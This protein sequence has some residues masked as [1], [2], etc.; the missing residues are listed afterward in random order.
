MIKKHCTKFHVFTISRLVGKES[1]MFCDRQIDGKAETTKCKTNTIPTL[2]HQM[3]I[4]TN[5]VSSVVL[6]PKRLEIQN[7]NCENCIKA[8]EKHA[9]NTVPLNLEPKLSD[10]AMRE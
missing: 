9:T 6:R 4:W 8:G 10:R 1:T 7:K 5:Q 2:I 3:H